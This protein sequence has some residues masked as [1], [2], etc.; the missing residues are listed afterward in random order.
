MNNPTTVSAGSDHSGLIDPKGSLWVWGSNSEGQ[1]GN[2]GGGSAQT[3][4]GYS[5]QTVPLKVLNHVVS[6]SSSGKNTAA[7]KT[8]GSL[9]MWGAN[10][11]GQLGNGSSKDSLIPVKVMDNVAAVSLGGGSVT[12]G[13]SAAIKTDGSL[14]MWGANDY[15]QLGKGKPGDSAV[16]IKVMDHVA[17]V[18]LSEYR[19]VAAIKTDGS[20]WMWGSNSRGQ[21]GKEGVGN[22]NAQDRVGSLPLQDIPVK[23][24]DNVAAVSLGSMHTAAIQ[25]DGSLWMWGNNE[26]GQLGNGRKYNTDNGPFDRFYQSVPV[27]VMDDVNAV[28]LGGSHTAVIKSDGSLWMFGDNG[29]GQLGNGYTGD[30]MINQGRGDFPVQ[31]VPMKLMDGVAS[32]SSGSFHTIIVKT[33]GSVWLSGR[34]SYGNLGTITGNGVDTNNNAMQSIPKKLSNLK[35]RLKLPTAFHDVAADAYYANSVKWAV[36][37][38]ITN[39]TSATRF[40]PDKV[41]TTG[42]VLTLL[43]KTQG[44]PVPTI[45][46]PFTDV[47]EGD[48]YYKAALW[49]YENELISGSTFGASIPCTRGMTV[50]YLWKLAGKPTSGASSFSDVD[51]NTDYAQAVSWSVDTGITSGTDKNTF[52]PGSTCT[53]GQIVTF[54]YRAYV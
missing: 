48:Y 23:I 42:E 16:P 20:L 47:T 36:E 45:S 31:T 39:G 32:V 12:S 24:M 49:A 1:L 18:S 13:Y 43:W 41:S 22:Q 34:S 14:W 25:T 6:V 8:D 2:G 21:L 15:G 11:Y 9:W 33:D 52:S 35:A 28:S 26:Y 46:N 4:G 44:S 40:S 51:R 29:M 37:K 53:R 3:E 30:R 17:S 38:G 5:Y 7:I 54:L 50:T 27:R 10:D 19:H